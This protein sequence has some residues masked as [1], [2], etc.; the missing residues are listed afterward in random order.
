MGGG[1]GLGD[2][3]GAMMGGGGMQMMGGPPE[4]VWPGDVSQDVEAEFDWLVNTEWKGKSGTL[5]FQRGGELGGTTKACKDEGSC[6]WAANKGHVYVNTPDTQ[7]TGDKVLRFAV[8]GR[9]CVFVC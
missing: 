5:V 1:G 9:I 2:I 3:L 6:K 4:L 8:R 7:R